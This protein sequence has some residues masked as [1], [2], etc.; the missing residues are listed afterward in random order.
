[1]APAFMTSRASPC[2]NATRKKVRI[3]PGQMRICSSRA[4]L[5]F[6]IRSRQSEVCRCHSAPAPEEAQPPSHGPPSSTPA[7]PSCTNQ[8]I[9]TSP[10]QPPPP[11]SDIP[12]HHAPH[13]RA[14]RSILPTALLL[15]LP[16]LALADDLVTKGRIKVQLFAA[17]AFVSEVSVDAYHMQ[18]LSLDNNLYVRRLPRGKQ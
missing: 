2:R 7:P 12:A 5:S 15:A 18:C 13:V 14:M 17:P 10:P 3:I 9:A 4:S 11:N 1:M 16:G 8:P 6:V